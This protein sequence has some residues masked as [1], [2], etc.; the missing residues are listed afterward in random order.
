MWGET[1]NKNIILVE[2]FQ[3]N[4]VH[5]DKNMCDIFNIDP[6]QI[7]M[8]RKSLSHRKNQSQHFFPHTQ[9]QIYLP[10]AV[11]QNQLWDIKY[12]R[13]EREG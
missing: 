8:A 9:I 12:A 13:T 4:R 1:G 10:Q 7:K 2:N 5:G 3:Y 6:R 11:F